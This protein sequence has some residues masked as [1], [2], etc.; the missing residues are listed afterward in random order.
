MVRRKAVSRGSAGEVA[1]NSDPLAR[2]TKKE[3]QLGKV[4]SLKSQTHPY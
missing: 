3:R 2:G 4:R 1:V